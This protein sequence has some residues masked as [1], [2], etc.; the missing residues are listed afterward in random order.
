MEVKDGA[1]N[2]TQFSK[3]K[4]KLAVVRAADRMKSKSGRAIAKA[5]GD[6]MGPTEKVKNA[7]RK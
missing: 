6:L 7:L 1:R 4:F 3:D 5:N 2:A